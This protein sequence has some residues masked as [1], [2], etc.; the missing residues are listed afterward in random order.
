MEN[1]EG[2]DVIVR[3]TLAA[4][5]PASLPDVKQLEMIFKK[6]GAWN[7]VRYWDDFEKDTYALTVKTRSPV[8]AERMFPTIPIAVDIQLKKELK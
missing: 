2:S 4:D 3:N 6:T 5:E 1:F 8:E 7:Y